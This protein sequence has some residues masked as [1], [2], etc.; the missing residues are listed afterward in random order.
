MI[1]LEFIYIWIGLA[2]QTYTIQRTKPSN[3]Y[4]VLGV[5]NFRLRLPKKTNWPN[6]SCWLPWLYEYC[7]FLVPDVTQWVS[8][9]LT[10]QCSDY[11]IITLAHGSNMEIFLQQFY[12][13]LQNW[14]KFPRDIKL[15]FSLI[16]GA[17]E[18]S[19]GNYTI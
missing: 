18:E 7:R 4:K 13:L 6:K 10:T 19:A 1:N 12:N 5:F 9:V 8:V 2:S 3:S 17:V 16:I 14:Y 15:K 11:R